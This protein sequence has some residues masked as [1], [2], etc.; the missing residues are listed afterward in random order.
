MDPSSITRPRIAPW[1]LVALALALVA[2]VTLVPISHGTG[3][4]DIPFWCLGCG[5]YALADGVANLVLFVPL[6]WA[7]A[8]TSVRFSSGLAVVLTSTIGVEWLQHAVI[9]GRVASVADILANTLGGVVGMVLPRLHRWVVETR[10]RAARA[11]IVYGV[12]LIACLGTG[13]ATQAVLSPGTLYWTRGEADG[14]PYVP[15]TGS[16][17]EV[18]VDGAP[19]A[20]DQW[21]EVPPRRGRDIAV[22]LTSGRPDT[23]LA[24]LVIAWMPTGQGWMWL[25][26]RDRDLHVH[27]ASWSDRAQLRGHSLWLRHV[28]PVTAGEPV[29]VRLVV[30]SFAYRIVLVT[31]AGTV[32]RETRMSPG[33]GWRL[34]TPAEP[35]WG[36]ATTLLTAVWLAALLWPLGYL[37]SARSRAATVVAAVGAGVGL[38]LLPIVSGCAWL[39]LLGWCGAGSG[40]L[41]GSQS[42]AAGQRM[43]PDSCSYH[44]A[45]TGRTRQSHHTRTSS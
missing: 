14:A 37:A 10:G 12:L 39:P 13:A 41:V 2:A 31:K 20:F 38:V 30:R 36:P 40:L 35:A 45:G 25:E 28:L 43:R 22:E 18:R 27:F 4:D 24:H 23:G 16:L 32:V 34:F 42:W 8:R 21:L 29:S 11:S 17:R 6:G 26:Q 5:D 33:D 7:L 3:G 9:P 15:F 44:A 19:I 1:V